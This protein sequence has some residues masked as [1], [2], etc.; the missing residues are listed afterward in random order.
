VEVGEEEAK[1]ALPTKPHTFEVMVECLHAVGIFDHKIIDKCT[2]TRG[3]TQGYTV[4]APT[5]D[6]FARVFA[7]L[8]HFGPVTV[9]VLKDNERLRHMVKSL[10]VKG[11]VRSS[12]LFDKQCLTTIGGSRI[13]INRTSAGVVSIVATDGTAAKEQPATCI[14]FDTKCT[15]GW[16]HAIDSVP[17]PGPAGVAGPTAAAPFVTP[18]KVGESKS[19][20]APA[21]AP[22]TRVNRGPSAATSPTK[23][24]SGVGAIKQRPRRG[25]SLKKAPFTGAPDKVQAAKKRFGVKVKSNANSCHGCNK[26]VYTMEKMV[27]DKTVWHKS[28]FKCTECKCQLA[29]KTYAGLHGNFYCKPHFKRL[30]QLKG[31]YDE[32]FGHSQHKTKW[33]H[34]V[35]N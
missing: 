34:G 26:T 16:L 35:V 18:A 17:T 14:K 21:R 9:Q 11:A 29:V 10:I 6:A 7:L 23:G 15:H 13:T 2:L 28:C 12:F 20:S 31:N 30:F 19:T 33:M 27:V 32:G 22:F 4:F 8:G 24:S 25:S 1:L 3:K 5:D